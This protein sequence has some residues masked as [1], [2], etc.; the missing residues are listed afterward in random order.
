MVE[1]IVQDR[2]ITTP[3][4]LDRTA[5]EYLILTLFIL[6]VS[7]A[8]PSPHDAQ[9]PEGASTSEERAMLQLNHTNL[10]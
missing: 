2:H 7:G 5:Q 6:K 10:T 1:V 3:R 4:N 8:P 9:A